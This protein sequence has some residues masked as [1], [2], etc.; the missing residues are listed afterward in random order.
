MKVVLIY[1]GGLDSTV[2]LYHLR[3][4]GHAVRCLSVDYGQRHR[5]ELDAAAAICRDLAVERRVAGLSSIAPLLAGSALTS[6]E[7]EVPDGPYD[8]DN[9]KATVVPNRTMLMLSLAIAWAVSTKS[10][11]VAYAAHG[12]DHAVY[13]DCRPPF[14][15][16]MRE[17]AR[18]CDRTPVKILTPFLSL[19]KADIVAHGARLDVPFAKTWSC[20]RGGET[21]CG[22]CATC[23]ER[24]EAFQRA[25][26]PDPTEY[27]RPA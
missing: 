24:R 22:T 8:P 21:H 27:A 13:P 16:A 26:V 10:D 5:R 18:L 9:M 25:D 1:S 11:A 2:L 7:I 6:P 12:G 3:A 4:Q 17:A 19:S 15:E 20:Y 23:V 14:V